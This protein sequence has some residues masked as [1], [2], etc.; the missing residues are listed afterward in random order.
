M[1]S[2]NEIK[3]RTKAFVVFVCPDHE[4]GAHFCSIMLDLGLML[5]GISVSQ[6]RVVRTYSSVEDMFAVTMS[7]GLM[8]LDGLRAGGDE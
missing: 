6:R 7:K 2:R 5:T 4:S 1:H 8:G 3:E